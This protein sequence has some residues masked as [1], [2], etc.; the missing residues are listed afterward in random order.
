LFDPFE[1]RSMFSVFQHSC[2]SV[3][4][5]LL[6]FIAL[7]WI[8]HIYEHKLSIFIYLLIELHTSLCLWC[9]IQSW[10]W[11][12]KCWNESEYGCMLNV[13]KNVCLNSEQFHFSYLSVLTMASNSDQQTNCYLVGDSNNTLITISN[14]WQKGA[15]LSSA[16][17]YE[18]WTLL[19][20]GV[21]WCRI[22][23]G[24]RYNTDT[25]DY[26]E[27]CH[28]FKLLPLSTKSRCYGDF[29]RFM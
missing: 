2:C 19:I 20:L 6:L 16:T 13:C 9:Q 23:V 11:T 4:A 28:S 25:Y 29:I 17:A 27:L 12:L 22:H 10:I 14:C 5:Y 7:G 15:S 8:S 24:V 18:A 1:V 26:I 21:S 3:L